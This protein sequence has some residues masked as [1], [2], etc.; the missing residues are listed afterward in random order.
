MWFWYGEADYVR[1]GDLN[2]KVTFLSLVRT[3]KPG[4]GAT[5]TWTPFVTVYGQFSPERGR[6]QIQGGRIGSAAAGVLRIRS[7]AAGREIAGTHRVTIN[8]TVYG[9][10]GKPINPDG[11]ND[12]LEMVV[13]QVLTP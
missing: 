1:A 11:H 13:E 3:P 12:M 5:E 10:Q 2:S 4:G 8:G 6:E 7:T 9:V